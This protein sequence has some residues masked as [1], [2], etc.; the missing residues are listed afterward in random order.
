MRKAEYIVYDRY[1][2]PVIVGYAKECSRFIGVNLKSF[3]SL[4][5]RTRRGE[6]KGRR[7]T[8]YKIEEEE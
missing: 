1:E 3:Q 8:V 6:M 4:V 2:M 5:T 7:Y